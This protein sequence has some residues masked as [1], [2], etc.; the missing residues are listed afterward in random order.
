MEIK[1]M[2]DESSQYVMETYKR[3]PVVFSKGREMRLWSVDGKEYL[4]FLAGIAVNVLGHC[5]PKIV[6]AIQ[7]Q[8]QRL[9]HVSNFYHND[10]QIKL[11][12]LL[13][14]H[15]FAD[16]VFFVTPGQR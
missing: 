11:A 14:K 7:K 10:V 5:H 8:A 9:I 15:S 1:K 13:I 3:F 16:R 6:V 2:L 12:R 4:D